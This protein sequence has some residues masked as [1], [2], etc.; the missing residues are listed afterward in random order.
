MPKKSKAEIK[1][2]DRKSDIVMDICRKY[3]VFCSVRN[4]TGFTDNFHDELFK[5]FGIHGVKSIAVR[6]AIENYCDGASVSQQQAIYGGV[7]VMFDIIAHDIYE[8]VALDSDGNGTDI[9]I[10]DMIFGGTGDPHIITNN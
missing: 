1:E 10:P 6:T 5:S 3:N 8:K 7:I 2:L 4:T 9:V